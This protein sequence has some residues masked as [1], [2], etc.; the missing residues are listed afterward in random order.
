DVPGLPNRMSFQ[1]GLAQWVVL[2]GGLALA[3]VLLVRRERSG[4]VPGLVVLLG[5]AAVSLYGTL[6]ASA[7]FYR[8]LQHAVVIDLPWK[9]LAVTVFCTAGSFA[10][11]LAH[12]GRQRA[13]RYGIVAVV[14]GL[15]LW[16]N[17]EHVVVAGWEYIPDAH[18]W[19][20]DATTSDYGEYTPV[21]FG[22]SACS[23]GDPELV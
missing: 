13:V 1:L 8:L 10:V 23:P 15:A 18:W 19:Q 3:G 14:L 4:R 17:R 16:S 9:C 21:T 7:W 2:A 22:P 5:T 20:S 6:P 12:L 11:G